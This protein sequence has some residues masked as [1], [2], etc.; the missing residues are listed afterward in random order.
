MSEKS[1]PAV[2]A[3]GRVCSCVRL[4]DDTPS[5]SPSVTG[6]LVGRKGARAVVWRH[7]PQRLDLRLRPSPRQLCRDQS[8]VSL[9]FLR[10]A[11]AGCEIGDR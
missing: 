5:D 8:V 3:Q 9:P 10:C 2:Q 4:A 7:A 6:G 1:N 11:S